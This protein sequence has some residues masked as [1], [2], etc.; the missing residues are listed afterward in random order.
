MTGLAEMLKEL[1]TIQQSISPSD[2]EFLNSEL[3]DKDFRAGKFC[4]T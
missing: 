2:A 4:F 1:E 3:A